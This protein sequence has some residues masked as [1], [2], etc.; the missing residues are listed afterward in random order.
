[1]A[2]SKRNALALLAAAA[3]TFE[4]PYA[5]WAVGIGAI[6]AMLGVTLNLILGLSRVLLAMGRRGDESSRESISPVRR[7]LP[8][9]LLA[10]ASPCWH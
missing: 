5:V 8:S 6:T 4:L 3:R 7:A 2:S 9:S 10:S 1:M